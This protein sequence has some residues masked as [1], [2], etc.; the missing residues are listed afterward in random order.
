MAASRAWMKRLYPEKMATIGAGAT[1]EGDDMRGGGGPLDGEVLE[2]RWKAYERRT[3]W[4]AAAG[5]ISKGF[6]ETSWASVKAVPVCGRAEQVRIGQGLRLLSL[7]RTNGL[8]TAK[9]R[10]GAK[11]IHR[12]YKKLCPCCGI[13]GEGE[14]VEHILMSCE[15]WL[16]EGEEAAPGG[17]FQG[18]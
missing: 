4:A 11:F 14:T 18:N 7:C 12:K 2:D 3:R 13:V 16:G 9:K 1:E 10:A 15:R 5:Y 8:W 17:G 6:G